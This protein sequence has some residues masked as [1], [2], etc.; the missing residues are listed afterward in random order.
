MW[1]PFKKIASA[2]IGTI[3]SGAK[4]LADELFTSKEEK[5]D[6]LLKVYKAETGDRNSARGL[7]GQDSSIQKVFALFFLICWAALTW[8]LLQHFAFKAIV[9]EDWQ[10]GFVGTIYGAI[11][12]KLGTIVDFFFGGS[13]KSPKQDKK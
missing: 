5:N 7:Y 12:T 4:E 3:M 10:I 1:N 8:F 13:A 11:N 9:L 6:F 2:T